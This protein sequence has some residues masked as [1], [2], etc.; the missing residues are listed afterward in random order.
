MPIESAVYNVAFVDERTSTAIHCTG[1]EWDDKL[2]MEVS[3]VVFVGSDISLSIHIYEARV[4]K[5]RMAY[6]KRTSLSEPV[7]AKS[8]S[9]GIAKTHL[10]KSVCAKVDDKRALVC[11]IFVRSHSSRKLGETYLNIPNLYALNIC[12]L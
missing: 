9:S 12:A 8:F 7:V 2:P 3:V 11:H 4:G 10:T 1:R 6:Q 5:E